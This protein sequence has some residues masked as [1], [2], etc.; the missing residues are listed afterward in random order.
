MNQ[1]IYCLI[2]ER[3]LEEVQLKEFSTMAGGAV[4]GVA[5]PLGAGPSGDVVYKDEKSTDK[6]HRKTS[7]KKK[8]YLHKSPQ[9]YLKNGPEKGRKRKFK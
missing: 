3:I 8:D 2:L 5:T 9:F 7:K 1:E 6:K 4:G